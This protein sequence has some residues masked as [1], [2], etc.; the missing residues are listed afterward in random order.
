MGDDYGK[1]LDRLEDERMEYKITQGNMGK[2]L[3]MT[4]SHYYKAANGMKRFGFYELQA[5]CD[6]ELDVY[7]IFTGKRSRRKDYFDVLFWEAHYEALL[8]CLRYIH[9]VAGVNK[10]AGPD[11]GE[12][13]RIFEDTHYVEYALY[14]VAKEQNIFRSVR[15]Y[16][17]IKQMDMADELAMDVKKL[18]AL[19]SN[20]ILPD[21]E[22]IFNMYSIY[23]VSPALFLKDAKCLKNEICYLVDSVGESVRQNLLIC[24]NDTLEKFL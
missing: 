17:G 22:L 16:K 14:I 3:K 24:V 7:H 20:H 18:R 8:A 5:M 21:S 6:S 9:M 19:E 4:Q 11:A 2:M 12:W 1:A 10:K 13:E 23:G 15:T